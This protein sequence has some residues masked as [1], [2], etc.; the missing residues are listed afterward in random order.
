[1]DRVHLAHD[2]IQWRSLVNC[3]KPSGSVKGAKFN[4][5]SDY[6]LLENSAPWSKCSVLSLILTTVLN[7]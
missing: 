4:Q 5:L 7:L 3:N 1:V 2:R 6:L